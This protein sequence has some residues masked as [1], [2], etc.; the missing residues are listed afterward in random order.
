MTSEPVSRSFVIPVLD[1]SP[2][3]PYSILTLLEDLRDIEGEVICVFNTREV[4]ERLRDHKRINKFCFNNLNA[5]V[6]RSWN[7]GINLSEGRTIFIMNAD[8][9]VQPSAVA[10]LESYLNTLAAAVMVGPRDRIW[11]LKICG[12]STILKKGSLINRSEP[13]MYPGSF[14]A[15]IAKNISITS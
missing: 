7:I 3:S 2:H 8:L 15:L 4:Y 11:I 1:F 12:W 9:H 5:G 10:Q 13:M 6:S 14:F